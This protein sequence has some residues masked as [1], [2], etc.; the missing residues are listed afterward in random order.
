MSD[1]LEPRP[2]SP[3]KGRRKRS[4]VSPVLLGRVRGGAVSGLRVGGE[5]GGTRGGYLR[6]LQDAVAVLS[7]SDLS[8]RSL[9]G[10]GTVPLVVGGGVPLVVG[11]GV[12]LLTG[13]LGGGEGGEV[14]GAGL[15]HFGGLSYGR[16]GTGVPRGSGGGGV[17]LVSG[18]TVP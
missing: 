18:S 7:Q 12:P 8:G 1:G 11:G 13:G 9:P 6:G 10:G 17:P 5:V 3:G 14:S 2:V 4:E 16:G 15:G